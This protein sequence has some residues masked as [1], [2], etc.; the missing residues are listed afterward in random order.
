[1]TEQVNSKYADIYF[2]SIR[3]I[4][5][6]E[7]VK[8]KIVEV[9]PK[10]VVVDIGFKSEGII[11]RNEFLYPEELELGREIELLVENVEDDEGTL[12]VSYQKAKRTSGW[13][14]LIG[15]CKENDLV[16]GVVAKKV[17]GGFMVDVFGVE[18]F[19]PGSLSMFKNMPD[20]QVLA[21][22]FKFK[23]IKLSRTKQN[24]IVSRRDALRAEKDEVRKKLW[25]ELK[26]GEIRKGLVKSITDFGAF[27]DL[28]GIDGLLHIGDMSWK[29][30]N[31]PSEIVAVGS[32][33]EVM[34]LNFDRS[35]GKISLGLK[36]LTPDPWQEIEEKYSV[37]SVVQGKI[38]NILNYGIFVELEKGIEGLVHISEVAWVKGSA[39]LESSFAIGDVLEAKIVNVDA[40]NKKI[41][42]S[43]RQ[44]EKDPWEHID[45]RFEINS[46]IQGKIIG[47]SRDAAFV[48][49]GSGIE[50]VVQNKDLSWTRRVNKPQDVLKK[51]HQYE[52]VIL[53][54]NPEERKV[55]LSLKQC[56]ENPW[57]RIVDEYPMGRVIEGEVVK[58]T[59]FGIFVKIEE[60][61]E[62]LIFSEEISQ[63]DK[64]RIKLG[65]QIKVKI[66]RVDPKFSKIGLSAQFD[67]D[68]SNDKPAD[69]SD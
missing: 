20:D 19:L 48:D 47:F 65:D 18:G 33:I 10:D 44:L 3:S 14:K 11:P 57:P 1:M 60:D 59:T 38:V 61:L 39:S 29:K 53:D 68:T 43:I 6:G 21:K 50:G 37:G 34:V 52:F 12:V 66:I 24:F 45:E 31:H 40:K 32:E 13:N 41:S 64:D 46:K 67:A 23:I 63:Q 17:K 28:G 27:I 42:L 56:L 36:Q 7:I 49:L 30:I 15:E 4:N 25:D 54:V 22:K 26:I 69:S 62:G 9:N 55:V 8:G 2:S 58:I 5:K 51:N 16:E 35:T